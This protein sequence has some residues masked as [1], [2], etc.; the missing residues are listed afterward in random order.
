MTSRAFGRATRI[1][2]LC[3]NYF[4][5]AVLFLLILPTSAQAGIILSVNTLSAV[6]GTVSTPVVATFTTSDAGPPPASNFSATITWGDGTTTAATITGPSAGTYSVLGTHTYADESS[7][8][9]AVTVNDS[10]DS[11]ATTATGT[12]N[13]A[14]GDAGSLMAKTFAAIVGAPYNGPVGT[15]IDTGNPFQV[16]SDWTA[17][18]NWGDGTLLSTGTVTG[19][20]TLFTIL[21]THTYVSPGSFSVDARFSDDA[22]STLTNIQ[23][24]STAN[25]TGQAPEPASLALLGVAFAAM[26]LARRRSLY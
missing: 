13:V 10:S 19:T 1:E 26:G 9:S 11:T 8:S 17:T 6:E 20:S 25:V 4:L 18:I 16:A 3:R 15:F 2:A 22:P 5:H 23:I 21:G 7:V 12:V 14:E 24:L